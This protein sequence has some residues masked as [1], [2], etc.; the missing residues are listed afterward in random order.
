M[1]GN[2]IVFAECRL[3]SLGIVVALFIEPPV[4]LYV[5]HV[6]VRT[7]QK[8][9]DNT[10]LVVRDFPLGGCCVQPIDNRFIPA[11]NVIEVFDKYTVQM[12]SC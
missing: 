11:V 8:H 1:G 12:F 2:H 7:R 10:D 5:H 4:T 3:K 6:L 9:S